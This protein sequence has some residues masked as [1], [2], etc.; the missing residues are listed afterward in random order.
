MTDNMHPMLMPDRKKIQE[1]N[2][3]AEWVF[4]VFTDSCFKTLYQN[5]DKI[6]QSLGKDS[7][8]DPPKAPEVPQVPPAS[9]GSFTNYAEVAVKLQRS[10]TDLNGNVTELV[11]AIRESGKWSEAGQKAT[12]K[13][14]DE[15]VVA[16]APTAP[17]QGIQIDNYILTWV[18]D[19]NDSLASEIDT[20]KQGQSG[21]AKDIDDQTKMI[22]ELQDQIK[23]L[24]A[25]ASNPAGTP[26]PVDTSNWPT[27]PGVTDPT[28]PPAVDNS[29]FPPGLDGLD[30]PTSP[31]TTLP[32]LDTPGSPGSPGQTPSSLDPSG[33]TPGVTTPTT[34]S[35]PQTP[36]SSPMGSGMDLMSSML[37]MMMQ[38]A[39]MRNMADQDLNSR[40][41]ELDPRRYDDELDAVAPPPVAPP[42][43]AQ[44]AT[45]QTATTAP[46]TQHSGTPAGTPSSTQPTVAPGRTPGADGSVIYTFPDGRTQKVSAMVAQ[47]L[48]GAFGN[49]SGTDA[50]KAYE[51]TPAKWSDKKQIGD[52]VDPYQL[53]TGDVATWD[54]R[55]AILVVFGSD[56]GGTLEA[57]VNGELKPFTPEMSD[58]AGEFGQF[59]G[60]VHPKGIELTAPAEGGAP[61]ATPGSADQSANAAMP[62]VAAP[63]G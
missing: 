11:N 12:N 2:Y 49:A 28:V 56:E 20:V 58:S 16:M 38:Q 14:I 54:K 23:K 17:P 53:M 43:T 15:K 27:T 3:P 36:V 50:Q 63:A 47:A 45:V 4:S 57:V 60:F 55:T 30:D 32:D 24:E 18:T 8:D 26:P 42:V 62:V 34:P 51:K 35:V 61:P 40:R 5:F 41:E 7:K 10:Y 9:V 52:R 21:V 25:A 44:P 59:A 1:G 6:W 48:D 31:S 29:G 22:K 46:P 13:V 33:T 19:A 39:M 37:P